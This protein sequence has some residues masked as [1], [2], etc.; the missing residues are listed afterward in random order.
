MFNNWEPADVIILILT[1]VVVFFLISALIN[2]ILTGTPHNA[3]KSKTVSHIIS[4][5]L[6]IVS[7]YI[8]FKLKK[9]G[10]DK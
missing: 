1:A 9:N 7:L 8:G 4:S 2:V 6:S 3:E 10:E 5:I